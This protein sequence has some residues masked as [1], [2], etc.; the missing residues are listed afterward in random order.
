[1]RT[2]DVGHGARGEMRRGQAGRQRKAVNVLGE[3][4]VQGESD[5]GRS[6]TYYCRFGVE[7]G[8]KGRGFLIDNRARL[9]I[10]TGRSRRCYPGSRCAMVVQ[11]QPRAV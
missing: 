2:T 9:R 4:L 6:G 8:G 11:E 5:Q 7:P 3:T 10:G 1:M